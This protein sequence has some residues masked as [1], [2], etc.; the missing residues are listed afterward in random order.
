MQSTDLVVPVS[1]KGVVGPPGRVV[2][3]RNEREEW[4]LPGGRLAMSDASPEACVRR[5]IDEEL[6]LTVEVGDLVRA[7][8][9]EPVPHRHVLV[10]AYR[11]ELVGAW[12]NALRYSDEHRGVGLFDVDALDGIP[13][14]QG[15]RDA[16][17]QAVR[18]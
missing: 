16:V 1:A 10:L 4:E 15:Y 5:E 18:G 2:L 12:P 17:A 13:L 14:P 11:C 6:G 3:L 8:R 9:Y 7:W